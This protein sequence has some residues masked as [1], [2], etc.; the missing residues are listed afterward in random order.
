[1][2]EERKE[3]TKGGKDGYGRIRNEMKWQ[4][5]VGSEGRMKDRKG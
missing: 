2:E 4:K 5:C 3:R 1:M